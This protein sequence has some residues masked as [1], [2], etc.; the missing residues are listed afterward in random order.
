M[1][2][3]SRGLRV[4]GHAQQ[5]FLPVIGETAGPVEVDDAAAGATLAAAA[6]GTEAPELDI[7]GKEV[8]S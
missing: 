8:Y 2:H 7:G 3:S 4:S 6:D 1:T 5:I